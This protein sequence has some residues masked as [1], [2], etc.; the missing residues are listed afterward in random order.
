MTTMHKAVANLISET[1]Y[2]RPIACGRL[3]TAR[4]TQRVQEVSLLSQPGENRHGFNRRTLLG[5]TKLCVVR[6]GRTNAS[7][8]RQ[9]HWSQE[10]VDDCPTV[11]V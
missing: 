11:N 1:V 2:R 3:D 5:L 10:N 8:I 9:W 4:K 7:G 6:F